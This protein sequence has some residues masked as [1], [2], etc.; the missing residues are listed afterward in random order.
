MEEMLSISDPDVEHFWPKWVIVLSSRNLFLFWLD[1]LFVLIWK[2]RW[3]VSL[4]LAM[5][6][7]AYIVYLQNCQKRE[8]PWATGRQIL[9]YNSYISESLEMLQEDILNWTKATNKES[10]MPCEPTVNEVGNS[11]NKQMTYCIS[12]VIFSSLP[13]LRLKKLSGWQQKGNR[14]LI[15]NSKSLN[16]RSHME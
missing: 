1:A 7:I 3:S 11:L 12:Q 10:Q 5:F 15:F 16:L 6:F 14:V 9:T 8:I 13:P 4:F 2:S